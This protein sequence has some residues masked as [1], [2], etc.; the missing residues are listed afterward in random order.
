MNDAKKDNGC[1]PIINELRSLASFCKSECP[2]Q[3][4]LFSGAANHL[5]RYQNF[6]DGYGDG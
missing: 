2:D 5:E 4:L 6:L 1:Q 3:A